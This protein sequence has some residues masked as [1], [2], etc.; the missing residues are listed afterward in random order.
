M[1][2]RITPDTVEWLAVMN[3]T[4]DISIVTTFLDV[5]FN[6]AWRVMRRRIENTV[7]FIMNGDWYSFRLEKEEVEPQVS[8]YG[9]FV[10]AIVISVA[11]EC[12][13]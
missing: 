7:G 1:H 5:G 11:L 4:P 8:A 9:L 6:A 13:I 2:G 10:L 3:R 12:L